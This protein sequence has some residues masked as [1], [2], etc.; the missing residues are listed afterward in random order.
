MNVDY[1]ANLE[2]TQNHILDPSDSLFDQTEKVFEKAK[3]IAE[4]YDAIIVT[5]PEDNFQTSSISDISIFEK[6]EKSWEQNVYAHMMAARVAG[7][8]LAPWGLMVL[9]SSLEAFEQENP[10]NIAVNLAK[11]ELWAIGPNIEIPTNSQIVTILPTVLDT[12]E[13]RKLKPGTDYNQWENVEEIAR[14]I[15]MWANGENRPENGSFIAFE[16]TSK[17]LFPKYV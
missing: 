16:K 1:K 7:S 15:H 2:A 8:M 17:I 3:S 6:Y 13:M 14:L 10:K 12:P 4:E 11:S 5:T 9:Q